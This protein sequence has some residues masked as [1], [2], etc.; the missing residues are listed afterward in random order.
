VHLTST[1]LTISGLHSQEGN[2]LALSAGGR[3]ALAAALHRF[4]VMRLNLNES[5]EQINEIE[6]KTKKNNQKEAIRNFCL[7]MHKMKQK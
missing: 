6:R 3:R 4:S 5:D 1:P 7:Q 2:S